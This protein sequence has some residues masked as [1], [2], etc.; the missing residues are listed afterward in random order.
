MSLLSLMVL[1]LLVGS[2][3]VQ[4][5]GAGIRVEATMDTPPVKVRIGSTPS[6]YQGHPTGHLP[7]R[8]HY[9]YKVSKRDRTIA[10]RLARYTGVPARELIQLKRWGFS[11]Y[12]IGRKLHVPRSVVRAAMHGR[13]FNRFFREKHRVRRIDTPP[14]HRLR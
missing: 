7:I 10:L 8:M 9:H 5:A 11:W 14:E 6:C 2:A 13:S 12:E 3:T 4:D 1:A